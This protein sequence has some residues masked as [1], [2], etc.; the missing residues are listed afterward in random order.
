MAKAQHSAL[1]AW[2]VGL[3]TGGT[4][5]GLGGAVAQAADPSGVWMV[6]DQTAKIRIE[7]CA[8]GYWGVIDWERQPGTDSHNPDP[9]KRGRPLLGTPLLISMKPAEGNAWQGKVYNPQDGGFYNASISL[10]RPDVLKL[11]GCMLIFCSEQ[12]WTRAASVADT[13]RATTG[14]SAQ[15]QAQAHPR[16][17]CPQQSSGAAAAPRRNQ[18]AR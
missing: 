9:S 10:E 3:T 17:V 2:I 12:R 13:G 11:Q 16:N 4:L 1:R 15:A 7:P 6:A 5:L 8:D 18:Q 14:A